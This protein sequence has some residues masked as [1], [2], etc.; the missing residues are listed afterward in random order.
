[1]HAPSKIM[2]GQSINFNYDGL[3]YSGFYSNEIVIEVLREGQQNQPYA[4]RTN[5]NNRL[6]A[7]FFRYDKMTDLRI[8]LWNAGNIAEQI[9]KAK[10]LVGKN[11]QFYSA[12][13]KADG[14]RVLTNWKEIPGGFWEDFSIEDFK[15]NGECVVVVYSGPLS[16]DVY[17]RVNAIQMVVESKE[18]EWDKIVVRGYKAERFNAK[19][20]WK[21]GCA[22]IP[23]DTV[24][25]AHLLCKTR[26]AS[27]N[28]IRGVEGVQLGAGL[29]SKEE[30]AIMAK[31]SN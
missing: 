27:S 22:L 15:A 1:M 12:V 31:H 17:T 8:G 26:V 28:D 30:I 16:K 23:F 24:L 6:K 9:K 11:V 2:V 4:I 13:A 25:A 10:E 7:N 20:V 21:F 14:I 18:N 29:F 5:A 19:Q 3:G